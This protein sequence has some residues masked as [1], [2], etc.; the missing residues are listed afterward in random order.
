VLQPGELL[1][2]TSSGTSG[3]SGWSGRR[4]DIDFLRVIALGLLIVYHVL[5]VY[6]SSMP[7]RAKS[8]H[9]GYWADVLI[10]TTNPWRMSLLFLI[11][12]IA[13]TFLLEKV[14]PVTFARSRALRLM[15]PFG[16][17]ILVLVPPQQ[18]VRSD[19]PAIP[20]EGY[21]QFWLTH[22]CC[23]AS[24][25]GFVF[26]HFE[27]VW[28]LPY[29][30]VYS[31]V[32]AAAQQW[33]PGI[34]AQAN[35]GLERLPSWGLVAATMVLFAFA[36]VVVAAD[37]PETRILINDVYAHLRFAPIFFLGAIVGRS[38]AF[39]AKLD[40]I[41]APLLFIALVLLII[42]LALPLYGHHGRSLS[43]T[44][45]L[46]GGDM[47]FAVLA[48]GA[49]GLSK[50]SGALT[51]ATDAILPVYLM[52]QTG[53]IVAA[54]FVVGRQWP[55]ALEISALLLAGG[56][57]PLFAYHFIIRD[58][59]LLR[60]LFG[61]RPLSASPGRQDERGHP[62][63]ASPATDTALMRSNGKR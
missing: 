1:T 22:G 39:W 23:T 34:V 12:G 36:D 52:H 5:L 26:P 60:W 13:A 53:I 3:A 7:W 33:T 45:A 11:G 57:V 20:N 62:L 38:G 40:R 50:P 24:Y 17:T 42:R 63:E 21:L 29:L 32:L 59:P 43:F 47:L 2:T 44:Q 25:R 56:A 15:V 61:L 14:R 18:F 9:A 54:S 27:H 58:A 16:F 51:Y 37:Y 31:A 41:R 30:F 6:N 55:L 10:M 46:Y 49:W 48:F 19:I 4:Y 8:V 28:F 35:R